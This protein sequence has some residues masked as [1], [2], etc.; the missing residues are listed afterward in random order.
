[1]IPIGKC[2]LVETLVSFM[3]VCS[4]AKFIY[5]FQ[6]INLDVNKTCLF[7]NTNL[8]ARMGSV[9]GYFNGSVSA[10]FHRDRGTR[11]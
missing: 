4:K 1:M 7:R 10:L 3:L 2:S 6:I 5:F 9:S 8:T 11:A